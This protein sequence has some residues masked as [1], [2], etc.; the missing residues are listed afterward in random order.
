MIEIIG[1]GFGR[2]GTISTWIALTKLGY[3]PVFH[4]MTFSDRPELPL[5]ILDFSNG[6][7]DSWPDILEGFRACLDFPCCLFWREIMDAFPEAKVLHT[8]RD[9]DDWYDSI[10]ATLFEVIWGE[11]ADDVADH[12]ATMMNK[13]LMLRRTFDMKLDDRANC[14]EIFRRQQEDVI[15]AVPKERLLV[16]DVREGWKPLCNFL[17]GEVP[18]EDFPRDNDRAMFREHFGLE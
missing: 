4:N 6:A 11:K 18:D 2:T 13:E 15:A 9:P 14:T 10:R 12:P 8:T 7:A 5:R 1:S 17:E 3:G 16:F